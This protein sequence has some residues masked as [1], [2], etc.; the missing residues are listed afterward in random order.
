[1]QAGTH[2]QSPS[3]LSCEVTHLH[4][5]CSW[6]PCLALQ[7]RY[8]QSQSGKL[9]DTP[10]LKLLPA[11]CEQLLQGGQ[12]VQQMLL[13]LLQELVAL[14]EL[15]NDVLPLLLQLLLQAK[16]GRRLTP[17]SWDRL[18]IRGALAS[19]FPPHYSHL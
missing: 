2:P 17:P 14:L 18:S 9:S 11:F 12:L 6:L 5:F 13:P 3:S 1:M 7:L 19:C 10:G 15:C 8:D 16:K 4:E